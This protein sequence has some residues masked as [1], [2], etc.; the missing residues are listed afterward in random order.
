MIKCNNEVCK[1][2]NYNGNDVK[3][4]K[5]NGTMVWVKPYNLTISRGG[6][7]FYNC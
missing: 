5:I 6:G 1:K 2:I 3:Y 4:F 7:Q